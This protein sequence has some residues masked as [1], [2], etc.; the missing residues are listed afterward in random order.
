MEN[1]L[2]KEHEDRVI[3]FIKENKNLNAAYMLTI[4]RDGES[5]VRSIYHFNNAL[6]AAEAYGRYKDWGFAKDFLTVSLYEPG[7]RVTT[8]ILKRPKAGECVFVKSDYIE[9]EKII[10]E[11]KSYLPSD[12]YSGLVKSFAGLFSRDNIRFDVVRFFKETECEEVFE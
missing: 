6:D 5:P 10:L 12:V 4:A 3:N 1:E 8:K 2:K 7:D 9:A 11:V